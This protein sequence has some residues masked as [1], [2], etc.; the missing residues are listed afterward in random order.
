[1]T[2][3]IKFHIRCPRIRCVYLL[4]CV[5]VALLLGYDYGANRCGPKPSQKQ[6]HNARQVGRIP[7]GHPRKP[8]NV[9]RRVSL[10]NWAQKVAP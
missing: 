4:S 9:L 5:C 3:A 10:E 7:P 8:A 6:A 2:K 1:M